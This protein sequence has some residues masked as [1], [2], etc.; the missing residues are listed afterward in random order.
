MRATIDR[1]SNDFLSFKYVLEYVF[2]TL[3]F[4]INTSITSTEAE[5]INLSISYV[6]R[7]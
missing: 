3:F 6:E 1:K 7:R 5:Q 2:A 4:N